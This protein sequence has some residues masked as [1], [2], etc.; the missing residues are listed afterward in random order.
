[1]S[2]GGRH[3]STTHCASR[4]KT[5]KTGDEDT[6]APVRSL[7]L[8]YHVQHARAQQD[9]LQGHCQSRWEGRGGHI[10]GRGHF[11]KGARESRR[12]ERA[13]PW[14]ESGERAPTLSRV[15]RRSASSLTLSLRAASTITHRRPRPTRTLPMLASTSRPA[16]ATRAAAAPPRSP[17]RTRLSSPI[18]RIP[19]PPPSAT[20]P[21]PA[22]GPR[23][24]VVPGPSFAVPLGLLGEGG[25]A[26]ERERR[27]RESARLNFSPPSRALNPSILPLCLPRSF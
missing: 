9:P 6:P 18:R 19:A 12:G 24:T 25:M 17:L 3:L 11:L 2:G 5:K 21:G 8:S 1:M 26:R 15:G 20:S 22:F 4:R 23:D 16:H 10:L 14:R 13:A 7:S 27:E